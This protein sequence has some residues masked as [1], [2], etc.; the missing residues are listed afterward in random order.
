MENLIKKIWRWLCTNKDYAHLTGGFVFG[1]AL[2]FC[3]SI[4]AALTA[5]IKDKQW[6]GKPSWRDVIVTLIGGMMGGIVH[7]AIF[8][9]I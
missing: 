9:H 4:A 7:Y 2:G 6:G 5:E 8:K 1:M 3:A